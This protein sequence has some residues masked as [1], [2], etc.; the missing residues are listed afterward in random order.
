[1]QND[2][3]DSEASR[4]Q[5]G[6]NLA[7]IKAGELAE[8]ARR[9]QGLRS[10]MHRFKRS[11]FAPD[12][13]THGNVDAGQESHHGAL[14]VAT[15]DRLTAYGWRPTSTAPS[16]RVLRSGRMAKEPM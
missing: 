10:R 3:T 11:A 16:T 7:P 4:V 13:C 15:A 6:A 12:L 14:A 5:R 8:A 2:A 1:M 9:L